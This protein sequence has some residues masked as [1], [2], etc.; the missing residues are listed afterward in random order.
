MDGY[1]LV[2]Q[3]KRL[4]M[5]DTPFIFLS[6]KG[7]RETVMKCFSLGANDYIVKPATTVY[8][9]ERVAV[10]LDKVRDLQ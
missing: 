5:K 6:G 8:L 1:T 3:L 10:A 9:R 4:G 7:D 2:K